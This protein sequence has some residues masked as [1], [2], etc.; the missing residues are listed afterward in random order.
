MGQQSSAVVPEAQPQ[1]A[2]VTG[3]SGG[4]GAA[5]VAALRVRGDVVIGRTERPSTGRSSRAST[6]STSPTS[7][8]RATWSRRSSPSTA[9]IDVL[10]HAA[11]VL[12][13]TPDP[14]VTTTEEFE[15]V[16]GINATGTFTI[17]R[18]VA[19]AM[20]ERGLEDGSAALL[21]RGQGGPRRLP[22]LQRQQDRRAAHHVV[23]GEDPRA[24][25]HLGQR[26]E[27]EAR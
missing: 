11:G 10:V 20:R 1:I 25:W 12:G 18:E 8:S 14:L 2:L 6:N 19:N 9:R 26:R 4:I 5:V 13:G 22:P 7:S 27:P 17:T 3:S 16:M 23:D 15:R 24:E 21:G